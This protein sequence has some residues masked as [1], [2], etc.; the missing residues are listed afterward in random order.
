MW[1]KPIVP[2]RP[3]IAYDAT[4]VLLPATLLGST[5]GVFLNKLCPNWLIVV[6]LV[7]LCAFSGKRTLDKAWKQREKE[8]KGNKGAYKPLAQVEEE[9]DK[10][11]E[12]TSVGAAESPKAATDQR[13]LALEVAKESSFPFGSILT[14]S[15]TWIAVM[16]LSLLKG[17]HGAPSLLGVLAGL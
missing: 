6:L 7:A 3:V 17:G 1:D 11:T 8:N 16:L 12:L 13:A 5:A 9:D 15:R 14:L 4:L 10:A 2:H